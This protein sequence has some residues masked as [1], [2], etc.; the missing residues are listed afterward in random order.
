MTPTSLSSEQIYPIAKNIKRLLK[1]RQ[2]IIS[3]QKAAK[4]LVEERILAVA[5]EKT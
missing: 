3:S 1:E 4:Y 2:N 5:R